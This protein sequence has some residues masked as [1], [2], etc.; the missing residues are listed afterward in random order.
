MIVLHFS[1]CNIIIDAR[2]TTDTGSRSMFII[3][4]VRDYTYILVGE[5]AEC[6]EPLSCRLPIFPDDIIVEGWVQ[7]VF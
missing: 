1:H 4:V 5:E 3:Q 2:T 7:S 6:A